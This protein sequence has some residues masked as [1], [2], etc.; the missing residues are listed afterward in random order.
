MEHFDHPSP[1][2]KGGRGGRG[3]I[4]PF[5]SVQD[6]SLPRRHSFGSSRNLSS[7]RLRDEPKQCLRGRLS[8]PQYNE[9][10][11]W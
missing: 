2:G 4:V 11:V 6:C 8:E 5:Y 3:L 9:G 10:P 1:Q 7:P